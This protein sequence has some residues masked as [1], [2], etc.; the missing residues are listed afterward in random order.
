MREGG[1]L[2]ILVFGCTHLIL[3]IPILYRFKA[4]FFSMGKAIPTI[5][6]GGIYQPAVDFAIDRL[7]HGGWI[8]VFPEGKVN[9]TEEMLRFKWGI[10]RLIMESDV[11]PI[12]I[13]MWHQGMDQV[14]PLRGPFVQ[15]FKPVMVVFGEPLDCQPILDAWNKGDLTEEETRIRLTA[16]M[17]DAI[18]QLKE[19]TYQ[20]LEIE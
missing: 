20:E 19:K 16:K 12:V 18:N 8:H 6:G 4:T 5:R 2:D 1:G 9:Q 15:L 7:N 10:G 11:C 17:V 13:P 3:Y 14:R